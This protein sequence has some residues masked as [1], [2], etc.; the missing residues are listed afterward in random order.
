MK[1]IKTRYRILF[2]QVNNMAVIVWIWTIAKT[3][4]V[5]VSLRKSYYTTDAAIT[6]A[7]FEYYRK[8]MLTVNRSIITAL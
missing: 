4:E 7:G 3:C 8:E 2:S 1:M 5:I 6:D